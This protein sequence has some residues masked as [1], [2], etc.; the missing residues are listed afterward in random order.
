MRGCS[1]CFLLCICEQRCSLR[2]QS[3]WGGGEG[4]APRL[5]VLA[6]KTLEVPL[7]LN[8]DP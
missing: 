3:V 2:L 6:F 5:A 8:V 1:S 4:A 7:L